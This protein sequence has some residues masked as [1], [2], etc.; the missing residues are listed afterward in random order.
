MAI[1]FVTAVPPSH[2]RPLHRA[3]VCASVRREIDVSPMA[4]EPARPRVVIE[5][6]T[7]CRWGLR[8]GWV[9]QELFVTFEKELG[10]VAL[11]PSNRAGVFDVWV[12][13][14]CVWCRADKGR[15]PELKEVKRGVRDV[16]RP[17]KDLG[18]SDV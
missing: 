3:P 10:E 17:E 14:V 6:C 8:A 1:T 15:F 18:H 4:P 16:V 7:G 12:D 11:R 9:A 5:F 13:N 2:R